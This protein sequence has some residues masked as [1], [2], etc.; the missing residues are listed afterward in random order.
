MDPGT[1]RAWRRSAPSAHMWIMEACDD[2]AYS[3]LDVDDVLK[4]EVMRRL[5]MCSLYC[6]AQTVTTQQLANSYRASISSRVSPR[7]PMPS[8]TSKFSISARFSLEAL[9]TH[10]SEQF[11]DNI[12]AIFDFSHVK[13]LM[14]NSRLCAD[15]KEIA[16]T[17]AF[18]NSS[19]LKT[20][21]LGAA[22]LDGL[23]CAFWSAISRTQENRQH[24]IEKAQ[25]SIELY[26][27]FDQP[28]LSTAIESVG[29]LWLWSERPSIS[30]ITPC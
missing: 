17:Y 20:E 10:A 27:S 9:V 29:R 24:R 8:G 2:I 16:K 28:K 25:R 21:T 1:D 30:R 19:V 11:I 23:M 13:P 15:L 4:K 5:T 7:V 6:D 26:F 12:S 22:A 3:V 14:D 18:N